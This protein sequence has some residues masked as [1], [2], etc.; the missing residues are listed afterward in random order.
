MAD[1][2]WR[3]VRNP[4]LVCARERVSEAQKFTT[5]D[6]RRC[7]CPC[8][9]S[10]CRA[11]AY[12]A[13]PSAQT[14]PARSAISKPPP[15]PCPTCAAV[16]TAVSGMPMA[17][18]A[19]PRTHWQLEQTNAP[20][21]T[22]LRCSARTRRPYAGRQESSVRLARA[23]RGL[24]GSSSDRAAPAAPAGPS[25]APHPLRPHTH[26]CNAHSGAARS[27]GRLAVVARSGLPR[28]SLHAMLITHHIAAMRTSL[29]ECDCRQ[30][31]ATR[32]ARAHA[33][34]RASVRSSR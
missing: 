10:H 24:C 1:A 28:S 3:G 9:P 13:R 11:S 12:Q 30:R 4:P 33:Q 27:R 22:G 2:E 17:S 18:P 21:T 5:S 8:S 29:L 7:R 34:V 26:G 16:P 15:A 14:A 20:S 6:R 19:R 32:C 31:R 25:L 23:R